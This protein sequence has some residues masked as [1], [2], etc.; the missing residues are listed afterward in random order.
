MEKQKHS[1]SGRVMDNRKPIIYSQDIEVLQF[2]GTIKSMQDI[3]TV[4]NLELISIMREN[5][6]PITSDNIKI[7]YFFAYLKESLIPVTYKIEVSDYVY[8][9]IKGNRR[10]VVDMSSSFK[11][12][13]YEK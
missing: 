1:Q 11:E 7:K 2:Q 3:L 10:V 5:K 8:R 13:F 9:Y 6:H 12:K 4:F